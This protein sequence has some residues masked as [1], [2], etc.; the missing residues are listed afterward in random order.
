MIEIKTP[1]YDEFMSF[2]PS[3]ANILEI[4][5]VCNADIQTVM[6]VLYNASEVKFGAYDG[7]ILVCLFGICPDN[8]LWLFFSDKVIYLP[9]SF[10][11]VAKKFI[12]DK[13]LHGKVYIENKFAIELVQFLGFKLGE[14]C[15]YGLNGNLFMDFTKGG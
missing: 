7:D 5:E 12:S 4:S 2:T 15:P 8:E 13:N 1:S 14:P 10:Y 11:R 3:H 6:S 9:M